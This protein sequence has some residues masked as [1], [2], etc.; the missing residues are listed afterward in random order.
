MY[1][2]IYGELR[3]RI[4]SGSYPHGSRLPSK[5]MLAEELGVSVI[6]T[7]KA[8]ELLS[9]EG[10]IVSRER[11]GYFVSYKPG[12]GHILPSAA[13]PRA[14][15]PMPKLS[16]ETMPFTVLSRA[17][18]RV[19]S[20]YGER[21]SEKSEG[22]GAIELRSAI[23][24]FLSRSRGIDS[25]AEDIV[26]GSGAE[27]LYGLI[28]ALL[29]R[30]RIYAKRL[31]DLIVTYAVG[32]VLM[33]A[34]TR[35]VID[36]VVALLIALV[37][38]TDWHDGARRV[39]GMLQILG[40]CALGL[41][42]VLADSRLSAIAENGAEGDGS[43]FARIYQSLD[44]ICGLLTHPWT[45]LTGYGAGNIINAVWA[46]AAKA[47]RLLDGLGMNGGAATGFAA[48]VNADTVWTMCAYTSVIAEY[49]LIGLAMLVGASMVCMTR[50]RTVCRGGADGASSDEL[51]H[52]V[53]VAD[54]ADVADVAG[55]NSG[56]GVAGAGSG[57]S[58]VWHKTVI[59]WLVLVAYLYI[60]CENYAFAALPLLVFAASKVRREPDFSRADASTRPEMDQNPE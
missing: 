42:G 46:G 57:E 22:T 41:L 43:F 56:G 6:T 36:S 38:R 9:D 11:S 3:E 44:P 34:G 27:Y 37:A 21:I 40:A 14:L 1:E 50:G 17:M 58:G 47:G 49:G 55:G 12:D 32:A 48:G 18:R 7:A 23:A 13:R 30:D 25:S 39:R 60:Q 33:Q 15:P 53:C 20:D 19:L 5:R 31:R 26:I 8:Y 10:Y 52:G 59:C 29:G 28:P 16:E 45:L 2:R 35:I 51:A 54:V 24:S 4:I